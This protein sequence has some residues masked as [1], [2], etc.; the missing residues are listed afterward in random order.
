MADLSPFDPLYQ[1]PQPRTSL[2]GR[3]D[4]IAAARVA[5]LDEA[6]PLLT[7]TGPGGVGKTRLA[8]AVARAV[9]AQFADGVVFV[10]LA[11]LSDPALLPASLGSALAVHTGLHRT[12]IGE[13]VSQ[14]RSRQHLVLLDNCDH[15]LT[16]TADLT[17]TLLAGCPAIQLLVT[18]RA[19]IRVRG[20]HV[21]PVEPLPLP[22][23]DGL[24]SLRELARNEAVRLFVERARETEP[25]F[26][27]Q[28]GV[29]E[30]IVQICRRLDGLPLALELAAA[31]V[32]VLPVET[33][34]ARLEQR[35]PLL[36]EGPRDAPQRQ[37]TLR[38]TIAWSY[39]LLPPEARR[40]FRWLSVFVGGF[41][42]E[43]AE[44]IAVASE[45]PGDV[46]ATI[47]V[48]LDH[49]LLRKNVASG[50][51]RYGMLET[52]REYGLEQLTASSET[53][54]ARQ[55]HAA[56]IHDLV[57]QAEPATTDRPTAERWLGRLKSERGN[58]SS[59]LSWWLKR[60]DSELALA[61]A[62][63]LVPYWSFRN[64][65]VEGRSWC[66]R[67]L[68]LAVD[69]A[70]AGTEISSLYRVCV[71]ASNEDDYD[72]ARRAGDSMLQT[73]RSSADPI[74]M[75]RAHYALC[76]AARRHANDDEALSHAL[77]AIAHA[78]EA[79]AEGAI[80]PIWLAWTLS[81]LGEASEIVGSERAEAAAE[82]ACLLFQEQGVAWGQANTLQMLTRFALERGDVARAAQLLS[83]SLSLRRIIGERL[84]A[85]EDLIVAAEIGAVACQYVRAARLLGAAESWTRELGAESHS[86]Q[87]ASRHR[88]LALIR[89]SP[90]AARLVVSRAEGAG[91]TWSGALNDA[92]HMLEA[93]ATEATGTN[94]YSSPEPV[95]RPREVDQANQRREPSAEPYTDSARAYQANP[96]P[97]SIEEFVASGI[98]A[99]KVDLTRREREV[100]DLL[101]QRLS[102]AEIADRL[103]IGI[104]TVEFHVANILSKLGVEN[105]RDATAIAVRAGLV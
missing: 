77:A 93:I 61:T 85:I 41:N 31:R 55:A 3:E 34:L 102:D 46:L 95:T 9:E 71:L 52:I 32:S 103:Y 80:S 88:T 5:L 35:L 90:E 39:D 38:D 101:A 75:V 82:E 86:R 105:R 62:G 68:A 45:I 23:G 89:S 20:E 44:A 13:I 72:R 25:T 21:L 64:D 16:A 15:M 37:R 27:L 81:F 36:T 66:E 63:A 18:S 100:L 94:V 73:A 104:R 7:L 11:S 74:G 40:L 6:V 84:G 14:L 17:S 19:P 60:G 56:Y 33:L 99:P 67:A 78:R 92:R 47:A 91:L 54:S 28:G 50:M 4:E 79:A 97:A 76:H 53:E 98:A 57:T 24:P 8:L 49:S 58:L 87:A 48:L 83:K 69:V 2:V 59:A 30:T 42:L 29:A 26:P 22:P 70:Y 43:A 96:G 12:S 51:A 1:L 65:F 10:D